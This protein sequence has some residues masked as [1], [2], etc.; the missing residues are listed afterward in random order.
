MPYIG[1]VGVG[2]RRHR[3]NFSAHRPVIADGHADHSATVDCR[4]ANLIGRLEMRVETA[5]GVDAGVED[6]AEIERMA[7]DAIEELPSELGELLFAL[8]VPEEIG[9]AL[10]DGDVGVHAAAVDADHGL[11][12]EA[13]GVAHV[14]GDLAAEELVELN[15]VGRG[16]NF[17][18]A[19]VD[20]ELAGRDLGVVLLV[21]EAHGALHFGRGVDEL[22]QRV[23]RQHMVVATG[24]DELELAG[25]V[26]VLL[27][28]L[29]GEEEAFDLSGAFSV[30]CLSLRSLSAVALEHAAQ[31]ARVRGAVLV[32]DVAE[33][34]ALCR[35]RRRR[36][37]PSRRRSSRCRGAG[38]FPSAR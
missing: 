34:Q 38:R 9:L 18:V 17:G 1:E 19:E 12:Q 10:G 4:G 26:V 31:I 16:H 2:V 29:A 20:F 13:G 23:E 6:E 28:V 15:L 27:G 11:G 30:Y 35:S 14:G 32:D 22:A 7:E 8:L 37:G 24:V 33:D 21:L 3:T 5:I 36:R 25:L